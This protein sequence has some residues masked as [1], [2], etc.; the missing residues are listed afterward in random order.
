MAASS[1]PASAPSWMRPACCRATAARCS[2]PWK[3]ACRPKAASRSGSATTPTPVLGL[4]PGDHGAAKAEP[5]LR[6]PLFDHPSSSTARPWPTR[7]ASPPSSWPSS[8]PRSLRPPNVRWPSRSRGLPG[9]TQANAAAWRRPTSR[10]RQRALARLDVAA[11]LAEWAQDERAVRPKVDRSL[12]FRAEGGAPR[13]GRGGGARRAGG[14]PPPTTG[15]LDGGRRGAR[16]PVDRPPDRHGRQVDVPAP[17]RPAGDPG[18]GRACHVPARSAD[19]GSPST[20]CSAASASATTWRADCSTFMAEMV[21][22]AAILNEA[23]AR[24][25]S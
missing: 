24:A 5:L 21:E 20:A 19:P 13:L 10:R 23:E 9:L 3:R 14:Q 22:T 12:T 1:P 6:P 2:P 11:G 7:C 8:T 4:L 25:A 16:A 17:E 15:C 18:P